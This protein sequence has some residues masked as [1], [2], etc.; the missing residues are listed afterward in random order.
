MDGGGGCE[1]NSHQVQSG[2]CV[3]HGASL[4]RVRGGEG[5]Y[6]GTP[7]QSMKYS[8]RGRTTTRTGCKL[9]PV[10]GVGACLEKV[11]EWWSGQGE[12]LDSEKFA[13]GA[14]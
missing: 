10:W 6:R 12:P 14:T 9:P 11:G 3:A 5:G 7:R 4:P 1:L 13:P 2:Q 8:R